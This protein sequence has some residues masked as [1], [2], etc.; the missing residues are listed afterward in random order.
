MKLKLISA[1]FIVLLCFL[2][3]P[4]PVAAADIT[5][6]VTQEAAE[7]SDSDLAAAPVPIDIDAAIA[8]LQISLNEIAFLLTGIQELLNEAWGQLRFWGTAIAAF[9]FSKKS[10]QGVD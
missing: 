5:P 7:D 10:W 1:I 9:W 6:E 3:D 2:Q 8:P 4:E